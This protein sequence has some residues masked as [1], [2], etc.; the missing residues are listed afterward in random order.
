MP[1]WSR[2]CSV[3]SAVLHFKHSSF[4]ADIKETVV[5]LF[6]IRFFFQ[7]VR[8]ACHSIPWLVKA[9]SEVAVDKEGHGSGVVVMGKTTQTKYYLH[10]YQSNGNFA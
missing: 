4:D 7:S 3:E 8:S 2:S 6:R 1:A 5:S 9:N 10:K